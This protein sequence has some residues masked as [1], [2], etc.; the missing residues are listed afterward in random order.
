LKFNYLKQIDIARK[1]N[2]VQRFNI[3]LNLVLFANMRSVLENS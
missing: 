1:R 3:V 2:G